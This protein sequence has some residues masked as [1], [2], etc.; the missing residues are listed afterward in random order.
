MPKSVDI[1]QADKVD[2]QPTNINGWNPDPEGRIQLAYTKEKRQYVFDGKEELRLED[3]VGMLT[4]KES[5]PKKLGFTGMGDG[6]LRRAYESEEAWRE[7]I[8]C[9]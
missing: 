5:I 6:K 8:K 7:R 3:A 9:Q 1:S 4:G 2:R